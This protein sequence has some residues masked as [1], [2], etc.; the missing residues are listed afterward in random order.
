MCMLV[1]IQIWEQ[2]HKTIV[3]A[4]NPGFAVIPKLVAPERLNRLILDQPM[5][6]L[7]GSDS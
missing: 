1:H 7:T 6:W 5:A 4:V 3:E 2:I